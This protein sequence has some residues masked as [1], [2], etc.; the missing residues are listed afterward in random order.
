[1]KYKTGLFSSLFGN[2]WRISTG[3]E[4][5]V[6]KQAKTHHRIPYFDI[7]GVR[8]E[9]GLIWDTVT[10]NTADQSPH[11]EGLSG[12]VARSLRQDIENRTKE[13]IVAHVL[14]KKGV[15]PEVDAEVK[16]LLHSNRYIAQSDIRNWVSQIPDIG[17]DLAHPYFDAE[18]LP[19]E[20]RINLEAFTE[21]SKPESLILK[22]TNEN[23]VKQEIERFSHLFQKLEEYPLS[24]EQMRAAVVNEDRNLLIAAAG[25]GKSSTIVAKAI[26]LVSAGLA[27]PEEILILAFNKDAQ[28]EVEQ[29]LFDLLNVVPEY[30]TPLKVKTFHG[31]GYEILS[32]TEEARPSISEFSTG[33]RKSQ[34]RYFT[35]L[36]RHL[37]VNDPS[38]MAAWQEFLI[39]D[40]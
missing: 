15:L 29:R 38:F 39:V 9:K 27:K 12:K 37:Y 17:Q 1:M 40:K 22:Q 24:E 8:I 34:T 11:L 21:I 26:Y 19:K 20:A 18:L 31:F 23:F 3:D 35:D 36:I 30:Q 4:A 6:C 5:L 16:K 10:V 14:S 7:R 32:E 25:S 33:G 13:T 2:A 28:V